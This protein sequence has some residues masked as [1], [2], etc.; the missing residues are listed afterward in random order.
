MSIHVLDVTPRD[1]ECGSLGLVVNAAAPSALVELCMEDGAAVV[2]LGVLGASHVV[3]AHSD[4]ETLVE[5]VSC[6]A[7]GF[8]GNPL[9]AQEH[10]GNYHFESEVVCA[11]RK[12]FDKSVRW[13]RGNATDDAAWICGEFPGDGTALTALTAQRMQ[14]H[15]WAWQ[16][17]HLYPNEQGGE[18][19]TTR[20]RWQ[21]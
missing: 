7:I 21:S 4:G 11:D 20:S 15:G 18:I 13:L 3:T 2:R 6:D 16:T 12:E 9:P 1:V 14:P 17:W 10:S 8:G 5:Q 19:V